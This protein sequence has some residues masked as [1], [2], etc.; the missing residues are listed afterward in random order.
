MC[1]RARAR[2]RVRSCF[3]AVHLQV[4]QWLPVGTCDAESS[5][6]LIQPQPLPGPPPCH[7]SHGFHGNHDRS[8][9][10]DSGHR[11]T[12]AARQGEQICTYT[13]QKVHGYINNNKLVMSKIATPRPKPTP[14]PPP[15]PQP[16]SLID[17]SSH[18]RGLVHR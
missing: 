10:E 4:R 5:H 16:L 1:A 7:H 9:R 17:T 18:K 8:V 2:V 3:P 12:G 6:R 14:P 13:C 11:W 15:L